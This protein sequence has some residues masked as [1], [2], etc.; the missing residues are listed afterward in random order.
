MRLQLCIGR[1][2]RPKCALYRCCL[3]S[4]ALPKRLRLLRSSLRDRGGGG[5]GG[6]SRRGNRRD[7]DRG[8]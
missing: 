1:I 8:A 4:L 6:C 2:R 7:G 5:N 3:G